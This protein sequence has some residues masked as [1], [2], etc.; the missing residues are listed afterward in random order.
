[1]PTYLDRQI[2]PLD[3]ATCRRLLPTAGIG[4][5]GFTDRAMPA[6]LPFRF[7]IHDG[8]VI[9]PAQSDGSLPTAVRGAVVALQV[10]SFHDQLDAGWSLT[11]VGPAR[12]IGHP[13]RVAEFDALGLFP[14]A[15]AATSGYVTVLVAH[16]RGWSIG[17]PHVGVPARAPDFGERRS[18]PRTARA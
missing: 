3:E 2:R 1:V 9:I 10:D 7:A 15:D 4:R 14:A 11:V 16:I 8:S 6:I 5:L 13:G 12:V 17:T 18:R